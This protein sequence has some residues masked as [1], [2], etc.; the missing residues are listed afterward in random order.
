MQ[1]S[2]VERIG[3][4]GKLSNSWELITQSFQVL[5]ADT[6]LLWLPVLSAISCILV[7]AAIFLG[8]GAFF[9]PAIRSVTAAGGRW[10]PSPEFLFGA[11]FVFYLANYFVIV[12]FN[13]ALVGAATIRLQGGDPTLRDGLRL[14]WDRKWVIF[15]WALLASTVGMIL[16]MIEG[17]SS[18]VGKLVA[19]LIGLAW[20]LASFLVVPILAYEE[21]G[22]FEALSRSGELFRKTWGEQVV[23]GFSFGLM[24]FLF[25]LPG[26]LLPFVG[27]LLGGQAGLIVGAGWFVVYVLLIS[28]VNSAT[29]GIF[30][31]ALYRYATTGEVAPGF[32]NHNLSAAW[33]PKEY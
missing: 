19:G 21:L 4:M 1:Q 9:Y 10:Q 5:V 15:Q 12:F 27:H 33:R 22:P 7:T 24:F 16:K 18:L 3:Q 23:G 17:R 30:V 6:E 2:R 32:H 28:I 13:T 29:H 26:L 11:F 14:A 20:T 31:A 25:T 8:G